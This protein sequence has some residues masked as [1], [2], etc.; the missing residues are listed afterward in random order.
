MALCGS[1]PKLKAKHTTAR[2]TRPSADDD[3]DDAAARTQSSTAASSSASAAVPAEAK[4]LLSTPDQSASD[5][6]VQVQRERELEQHHRKYGMRIR[7]CD[8]CSNG[9]AIA[10]CQSCPASLCADCLW[11]THQSPQTAGELVQLGH[12]ITYYMMAES[13]AARD[14]QGT[15]EA[16]SIIFNNNISSGY[17]GG[18][19][20]SSKHCV[21][22][23]LLPR[24]VTDPSVGGKRATLECRDGFIEQHVLSH[25]DPAFARACGE[26]GGSSEVSSTAAGVAAGARGSGVSGVS[27]TRSDDIICMLSRPD[28]VVSCFER[29]QHTHRDDS[30]DDSD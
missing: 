16:C 5:A 6:A 13:A 15:R 3:A 30:D 26:G 29:R 10:I 20:S 2:D 17:R 18:G 23:L 22:Q 1:S 14:Q 24:V 8:V 21:S 27:G 9:S 12:E 28:R 4:A 25:P 19:S 11:T 7:A